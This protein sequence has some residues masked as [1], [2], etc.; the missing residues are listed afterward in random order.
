[1]HFIA[2]SRYGQAAAA[3]RI[4]LRRIPPLGEKCE[5]DSKKKAAEVSAA[6][7]AQ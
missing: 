2:D 4:A 6:F 3:E 1:M 5:I 7:F